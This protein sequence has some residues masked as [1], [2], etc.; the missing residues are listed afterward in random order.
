LDFIRSTIRLINICEIENYNHNWWG[1]EGQLPPSL[2]WNL[3]WGKRNVW[4]K[5]SKTH[6]HFWNLIFSFVFL[7]ISFIVIFWFFKKIVKVYLLIHFAY[8][9]TKDH[10][11]FSWWCSSILQNVGVV[12]WKHTTMTPFGTLLGLLL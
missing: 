11:W 7:I 3:Y 8:A 1:V 10:L 6:F 12:G 2:W 4:K 9:H 5:R